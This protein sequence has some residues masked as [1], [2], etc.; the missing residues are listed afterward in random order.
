MC[1]CDV[2]VS[3]VDKSH[4]DFSLSTTKFY[5]AR[6][7]PSDGVKRL[8]SVFIRQLPSSPINRLDEKNPQD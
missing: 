8:N 2:T 4:C 3:S 7:L 5:S 1:P 6:Q